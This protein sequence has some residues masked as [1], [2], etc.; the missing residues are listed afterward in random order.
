MISDDESSNYELFRDI[1]ATPLIEKCS[2]QGT[3]PKARQKRKSRRKSAASATQAVNAPL[4]EES[5]DA[6]ELAEFIDV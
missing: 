6:E 1:L 3:P 5:N 2:S 4:S